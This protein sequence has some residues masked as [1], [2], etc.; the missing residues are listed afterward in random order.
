MIKNYLK[1]AIR[2]FQKNK[3]FS[4]LNVTGLAL[5]GLAK[6]REIKASHQQT[7]AQREIPHLVNAKS[8]PAGNCRKKSENAGQTKPKQN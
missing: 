6:V 8:F 5:G 2:S 1:S 3:V 4:V 7:P